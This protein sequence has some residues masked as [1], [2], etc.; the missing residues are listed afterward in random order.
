MDKGSSAKKARDGNEKVSE[1]SVDELK[2]LIKTYSYIA[3]D[4]ALLD[5]FG[6]P[7]EGLEFT[8]EFAQRLTESV[9]SVKRGETQL[10]SLEEVSKRLG[11]D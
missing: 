6:D 9:E 3:M 4:E 5:F 2:D 10:V 11:L 1:L 7:D 8:E